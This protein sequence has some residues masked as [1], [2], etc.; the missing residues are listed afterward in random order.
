[1]YQGVS[2][3]EGF[4]GEPKVSEAKRGSFENRIAG[5]KRVFEKHK[6]R[7]PPFTVQKTIIEGTS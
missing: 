7:K 2:S 4:W 6:P 5:Y 3:I 1:M